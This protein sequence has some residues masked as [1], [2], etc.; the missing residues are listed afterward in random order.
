MSA[1]VGMFGK[2][3]QRWVRLIGSAS[4]RLTRTILG[5]AIRHQ[6]SLRH[7]QLLLQDIVDDS[8]ALFPMAATIWYAAQPDM[9]DKPGIRALT[10]YFCQDMADRLNPDMKRISRHTIDADVY[11]LSKAIMSG[12][13]AWLEEGI[14]PLLDQQSG[15]HVA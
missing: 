5:T 10:D 15:R 13:Y 12:E 4:R 7:K 14:V 1:G 11:R 9:R 3:S 6:Q 2:D 8:L